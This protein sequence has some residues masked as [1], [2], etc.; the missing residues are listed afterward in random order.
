[1]PKFA[2]KD[3]SLTIDGTDLS[4]HVESLELSYEAD[5]VEVTSMGDVGRE[6]TPGLTNGTLSVTFRQNYDAGKVDATLF[7]LL[8]GA[9]AA[10]V[11][12]PTSGAVAATNPSFTATA[13]LSSY[14]GPV[15]GSVGDVANASAEFQ[16][17]GPITRATL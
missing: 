17:S 13:H 12:K 2:L 5:M 8:G 16:L 9:S 15:S 4:D 1:M 11:V 3:A 7:P 14:S 10:I 6:Y